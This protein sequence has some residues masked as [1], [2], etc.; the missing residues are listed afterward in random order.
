MDLSLSPCGY[1]G[2]ELVTTPLLSLS[3]NVRF[4]SP[5]HTRARRPT[6]EVSR[7]AREGLTKVD[8]ELASSTSSLTSSPLNEQPYPKTQST[9]DTIKPISLN[10]TLSAQHD[11]PSRCHRPAN[12]SIDSSAEDDRFLPWSAAAVTPSLITPKRQEHD[13]GTFSAI[14]LILGK[15]IGVG[16]YSVPSSIFTGLGSV[17]MTLMV[18]VVGALISFC[19]L[20]VYLDLGTALPRSGGERV[21]LER[22]LKRPKMLAPC[23]FMSYVVLLGFSAPNCIVLGEYAIAAAGGQQNDWNVRIIAVIVITA[24]CLLHE[25]LPGLGLHAINVLGVGKML[26]LGAVIVSG[27]ASIGL[28]SVDTLLADGNSISISTA[29]RNFTSIWTGSTSKPYEYATALLKVLYC[30]RGYSAANQVL[31]EVRNPVQTLKFAAPIALA[32]ASA[33]YILA[34]IAYFCVVEKDDFSASGVVIASHFLRNIFGPV[35][36]ERIL[37]CFIIFSAFGNVAATSFAQA[38]VNQ[39]LGTQGLLPFSDFWRSV[40]RQD[41][42]GPGLLLHWLVTVMVIVI[43][44]PGEIYM[45][46]VEIGGYPVSVISVALSCGLLYL[47]TSSREHWR[48]PCPARRLYVGIFL[49]ANL[50]LLIL[51]W[52]SPGMVCHGENQRFAYY[53]YPATSLAV[54]ALGA[55]YWLYWRTTRSAT[56]AGVTAK[57][58]RVETEDNLD[59]YALSTVDQNHTKPSASLQN[60]LSMGDEDE[61]NDEQSLGDRQVSQ[62]RPADEE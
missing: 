48:S 42:P 58:L 19:G 57:Y 27:L 47:Q 3:R 25:R 34:N 45:F 7:E 6:I 15:T 4:Q 54:L 62:Y 51:P 9:A 49:A 30:F 38:R 35:I 16:V 18:W 8:V 53:A 61:D 43:P 17:G 1:L 33:G 14:N 44:P 24:A 40:N 13:I 26:I 32:I 60:A 46:L 37:P 50:L 12:L 2:K 5:L 36:G 23:M 10:G 22:I 52:F 20:A 31:S 39:E 21:Y 29:Q 55:L 11:R 28:G 56:R 41:A 59:A